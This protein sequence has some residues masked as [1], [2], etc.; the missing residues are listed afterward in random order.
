MAQEA[1]SAV[2]YLNWTPKSLLSP[3]QAAALPDFCSG[4]Y[5]SPQLKLNQDGTLQIESDHADF[6][7]AGQ[8]T[9]KGQV[10]LEKDDQVI[11]GEY[12]EFNQDTGAAQF[13]GAIVFRNEDIAIRAD[14]LGYNTDTEHAD[15]TG[16]Y[17][18]VTDKHMR[19][20]ADRIQL[21]GADLV[22]F[23]GAS[24]TFCEPQQNHWDLKASEIR[25]NE[26]EG[27]GEAYHGRL[28]IKEVPILYLPYYRFPI[29]EDRLT[30]FLDPE[31]SLSVRSAQGNPFEDTEIRINQL[32]TPFYWNIAPN[33][34]DTITPR[35]VDGH[36][37]LL[38]NEFRY[39]NTLGLGQFE[40]S[41][42][43]HDEANDKD[44]ADEEYRQ[45][46]RW[47][48]A[49]QHQVSLS[50]HWNASVDYQ[51]VSDMDYD[52]DFSTAGVINRTSHLKQNAELGYQ[53]SR[54]RFL[55]RIEEYQTIDETISAD[56]KPFH[57]LPQVQIQGT[58]DYQGVQMAV[59][60]DATRFTRSHV[61]VSAGVESMDGERFHT[62]LA[63]SYPMESSYGFVRPNLTGYSTLY[64][65][66]NIDS[67]AS[68]QGYEPEIERQLYTASLDMGLFFERATEWFSDSYIQTLEPRILLAYTPYADQSAIPLFDTT[69]T[70]FSYGQIF[71]P[72]RFTGLDRIGDTQQA[73]I[74]VTS[75]F[76]NETGIEVMRASIGQVFYFEDRKVAL[77]PGSSNQSS[78]DLTDSSSLAGEFQWLFAKHWRFKADAQ[79][80][81]RASSDEEPF[82]KAS[83]QLNYLEP[84]G[85]LLDMNLSHVE[86][87]Q[88]K[89]VGLAFFAPLSDSW[90]LYGQKK[91]DIYPYTEANKQAKED[92]NLL[93]IEG[94]IGIEYQNCCWRAQ[95]TYEE[96]TQSDLTK[97]YQF[98]FQ[99]HFKGLG[100]LGSNSEEI[101]SERIL[102]YDQRQ[103]HDY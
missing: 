32:A 34:D 15:L 5:I 11:E 38:Q 30:G 52:N 12:L 6:Y 74:G 83:V 65:F 78:L 72:N 29:S 71:S 41:Y 49:W 85:F 58:Q 27:Y 94:L 73:S 87:E 42:L 45:K 26:A 90:A 33:Y 40:F 98:L 66:Q 21:K 62:Q 60:A 102:G 36:G 59:L 86:S 81:P 97:D 93:N 96:H 64:S 69:Q 55:T 4:T 54:W 43:G 17:Y 46:E 57:R 95:F 18:V 1:D 88:Q 16:A 89:Q 48:K 50:Q 25:L 67:T 84:N 47:S 10:R 20:E 79:Y 51:E 13:K 35:F 103:I 14:E 19:G 31:I 37:I 77:A 80:D 39:L 63:L 82:E 100:I 9:F 91:Q 68:A 22:V 76:L 56:A 99:L 70:S 2:R 44:A 75:R 61:G 92:S 53:D 8:A 7:E 101:L 24:Y 3:E 28:R 23:E